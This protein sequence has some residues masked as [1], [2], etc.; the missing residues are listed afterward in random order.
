MLENQI[1]LSRKQ[2]VQTGFVKQINWL[3]EKT[4]QKSDFEIKCTRYIYGAFVAPYEIHSWI[5]KYQI[6]N[7]LHFPNSLF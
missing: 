3:I 4:V 2:I 6:N 5:L 7:W 1:S